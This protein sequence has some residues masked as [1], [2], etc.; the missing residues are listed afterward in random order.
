MA[1]ADSDAACARAIELQLGGQL[2][3]AQ[4]AYARILQLQPRHAT[5]NYALGMLHV[6]ARRPA[7]A[8]PLLQIALEAGPGVPDYWLGYLEA[9]LLDGQLAAARKVLD[10]GSQQG[11]AAAEASAA[12]AEFAARLQAAEDEAQLLALVAGRCHADARELA[13]QLIGRHPSRSCAW[14][15]LGTLLWSEG[16]NADAE[17]VLAEAV[18]LS[19]G[20]AEA[21]CNY[22][23]VLMAR[24]RF[25][26]AEVQL[27]Q[28]TALAPHS[29]HFHYSL[30]LALAQQARVVDGEASFRRGLA[31]RSQAP[32]AGED[33]TSY[34]NLLFC[35]AHN[36]ALTTDEFFAEHL[37]F[38]ERAA[39]QA[40]PAR[41]R[42]AAARDPGRRLNIGF[43]SG[44]FS[45]HPVGQFLEPVV[46]RLAVR[47]DLKLH[48]YCTH[49]A[50]DAT[51]A[52]L[53]P[54]F[55]RWTD[56][57]GLAD[58]DLAGRI[59]GDRID[60]LVDLTGHTWFNRLPLFAWRPAP[61]QVSW[62][63]YPGTTGLA[64]MD[65]YI[66]DARWL[67]P[68]AFDA[69]FTEKLVHL[70]DRWAYQV[71]AEAA[72]VN[73]LPAQQ[74]GHLTFG[75]MHR[76]GKLND[77]TLDLWAAILRA[78]PDAMLRLVSVPLTGCD[79]Q[80][81]ERFAA[82]G[83]DPQR[84]VFHAR[85]SLAGYFGLHHQLDIGL[86][87]LGYAGGTTTM[88]ALAMGVPT[89]TVAGL[90]PQARAG[91]GIL[92]GVGLESFIATDAAD[93]IARAQDWS[94][95]LPELAAI[96]AGLR[97]RLLQSPAGQP[98]LIAAH[99][100]RALRHMWQRW[101]AGDA[102]ASFATAAL[103]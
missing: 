81:R 42:P 12:T 96:R 7:A 8:L 92:A 84:L 94:R 20:D 102:P 61:I 95:R 35:M 72:A 83:V 90:T 63:G 85:Q 78:V 60:I 3:A 37:R 86:D 89:L 6:Q 55:Q 98:D 93:C 26:A 32:L 34:S 69:Q 97:E 91:A 2:E 43:I 87:T 53:R 73:P 9:L 48:A 80:L 100:A 24:E 10:L 67:P 70:P 76:F 101:C 82:L 47:G 45:G 103:A 62:L 1:T 17:K 36:P 22:G 27:R 57:D 18:K 50:A 31:L 88:H 49:V 44:D 19:P 23:L 29:A 16:N 11:L 64:A 30:G 71:P 51:T 21:R 25:A 46:T 33:A 5:A 65:Y 52:R 41:V 59:G 15:T 66:A 40:P 68:G 4:Q 13:V 28:A 75:S 74:T 56:V 14:K 39:R 58:A 54:A 99:V 77:A 38:G 79:Q